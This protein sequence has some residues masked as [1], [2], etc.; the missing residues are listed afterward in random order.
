MVW[1]AAQSLSHEPEDEKTLLATMLTK[2][3]GFGRYAI[4]G[5]ILRYSDDF[6]TSCM[7][8]GG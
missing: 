6:P 1:L 7:L 3:A 2:K 5:T 8:H 4:P